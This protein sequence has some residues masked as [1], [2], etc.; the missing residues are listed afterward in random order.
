MP[1]KSIERADL[2]AGDHIYVRRYRAIY[3][4]HGIY[5]GEDR[6]VH[7]SD[8]GG[9]GNKSASAVVETSLDEFLI[10]G[11]LR[12]RKHSKPLPSDE[13]VSRAREQLAR[14]GYSLIWN[15]CEHFATF[16][17]TGKTRSRQVKRVAMAAVSLAGVVIGGRI[18][19][20]KR[21]A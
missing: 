5:V 1:S 4:H 15:N 9:L 10:G 11:K 16:C 21:G 18:V 6:V 13:I 14:Q 2:L 12:C 17:A 8:A 19:K 20:S 3:S 7:Y